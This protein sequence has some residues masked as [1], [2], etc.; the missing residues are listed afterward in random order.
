M[1]ISIRGFVTAAVLTF[2]TT[3]NANTAIDELKNTSASLLDI[4][5]LK[6][7]IATKAWAKEYKVYFGAKELSVD[8]GVNK[9]GNMEFFIAV[10][11]PSA[12]TSSSNDAK[13]RCKNVAY[14]FLLSVL[15]NFGNPDEQDAGGDNMYFKKWGGYFSPITANVK[16]IVSIGQK[17]SKKSLVTVYFPYD[18]NKCTVMANES[19]D[20]KLLH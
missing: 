14:S 8:F 17:I 3:A 1:A 6:L 19:F 15:G 7:D 9:E 5:F 18:N 2:T 10:H 20:R 11:R 13:S 12:H 4:G 16:E